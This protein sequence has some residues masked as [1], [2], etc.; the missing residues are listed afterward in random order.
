[1]T[2]IFHMMEAPRTS[3]WGPDMGLR[4]PHE[5][6]QI[7]F[8]KPWAKDM[9]VQAFDLDPGTVLWGGCLKGLD[10]KISWMNTKNPYTAAP[11]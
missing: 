4:G 1:M 11:S 2:R 9:D 5:V 8:F 6:W 3:T 10:V 7:C